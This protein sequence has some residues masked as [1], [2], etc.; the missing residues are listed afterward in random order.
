MILIIGWIEI[1]FT[2]HQIDAG[3]E[4]L[5]DHISGLA[6]QMSGFNQEIIV[7]TINGSYYLTIVLNHNHDNYYTN[8]I[9]DLINYIGNVAG[10]SYGIIHVRDINSADSNSFTIWR[11]AKSVVSIIPDILL[12][13]CDPTIE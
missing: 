13:P 11:L 5:I 6:Q 2:E 8:D 7:R 1:V 3:N 10:E 12:S 4:Y 9:L